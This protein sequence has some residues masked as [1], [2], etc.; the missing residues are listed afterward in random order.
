MSLHRGL[1]GFSVHRTVQ[2]TRPG[3]DTAGSPHGDVHPPSQP[4]NLQ[5]GPERD[6]TEGDLQTDC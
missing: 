1:T 5:T 2:T 4:P 6:Q 3:K